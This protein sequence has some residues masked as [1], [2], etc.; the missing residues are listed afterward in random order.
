MKRYFFISIIVLLL[1]GCGYTPTYE[2]NKTEKEYE[3]SYSDDYGS[4]DTNSGESYYTKEELES[5]SK[6]PSTDPD[7]YNS[8]GEYVPQ[9]GPS[10]N[11]A[12]YNSKGEYK[13]A[14]EMTQEEIQQELLEM[15]GE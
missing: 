4:E 2:K 9:D 8:S 15:L 5:D 12:D 11:P 13:P 10:S 6:A 7:D 3:P 1:T 14:D